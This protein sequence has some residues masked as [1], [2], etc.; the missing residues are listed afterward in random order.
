MRTKLAAAVAVALTAV[1]AMATPAQA[2]A[3]MNFGEVQVNTSS[4]PAS[5][6]VALLTTIGGVRAPLS[7]AI[8]SGTFPDLS[9]GG[10]GVTAAQ[11]QQIAG[12]ALALLA[13]SEPVGYRIDSLTTSGDPDFALG[14][15]CVGADGA[16]TPTCIATVTFTPTVLGPRQANVVAA[17]TPTVGVSALSDALIAAITADLGPLYGVLAAAFAALML[18]TLLPLLGGAIGTAVNPVAGLSGTGVP[19]VV[20]VPLLTPVA[21]AG[22]ALALLLVALVV[23]RRRAA[24]RA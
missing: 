20:G 16:V 3:A 18:P 23:R 21:A 7:A 4:A 12:D 1:V 6:D 2:A 8:D 5:A 10:L 9:A 14:G 24:G 13:D 17:I 11:V 22:A 19:E 15:T